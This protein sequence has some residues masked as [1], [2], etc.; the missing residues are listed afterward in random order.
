MPNAILFRKFIYWRIN[1]NLPIYI[2]DAFCR[3]IFTGNPAAVVPL[4]T[5]LKDEVLQSIAK[6]NNLSETAFVIGSQEN[7]E[8]RWFTPSTEVA[9]CGH[10]TLA[11]A[12][13]IFENISRK[14]QSLNLKTVQSGTLTVERAGSNYKMNFPKIMP[15]KITIPVDLTEALGKHPVAVYKASYSKTEYDYLALYQ[16]ESDIE[17]LNPNFSKLT[18]L[19]ARGVICTAKGVETDIVS[20]Y[21]APSVGVS[22]DPFTGSAHCI[23]TP[24]WLEALNKSELTTKQG[25]SRKG[26]ASCRLANGRVELIGK[27]ITY[28]AGDIFI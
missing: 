7:W 22:E 12:H 23:L 13:A 11:A 28:S 21:F 4:K 8:I 16:N 14:V 9:L 25:L 2:V 3:P 10:A 24:Y 20:R 15:S 5:W 18:M 19:D 17:S 1:M 26:W 27:A 6:E